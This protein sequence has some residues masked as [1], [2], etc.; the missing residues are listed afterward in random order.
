MNDIISNNPRDSIMEDVSKNN[1][2]TG[3]R[4]VRP[5]PLD[6]DVPVQRRDVTQRTNVMWLL[7]NLAVRNKE[8]AEFDAVFAK[9]KRLSANF[10]D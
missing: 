1:K 6:M 7:R 8:H 2:P 5:I 4:I 10:K 3:L 9:L